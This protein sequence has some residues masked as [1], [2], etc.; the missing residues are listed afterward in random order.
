[1]ALVSLGLGWVA[2]ILTGPAL[3]WL[4]FLVPGFLSLPLL[5][6][7]R[8]LFLLGLALLAFSLGGGRIKL[9][10]PPQETLPQYLGQGVVLEGV[11]SGAPE[12][13]DSLMAVPFRVK[14]VNGEE[15]GG[16]ARLWVS[17]REVPGYGDR[18]RVEGRL[19]PKY[20]ALFRPRLEVLERGRGFYPWLHRLRLDLAGT[21]TRVLPEPPAALAQ[22]MVLGLRGNIPQDL[23]Q[24]F[25][26][27]GT[28][29]ILSISG[30]HVG[31]LA[32]VL[33]SFFAWALG[34]ERPTY[35]ILA[36]LGVWFYVFLA[37]MPSPA[38]RSGVMGS[39]FL[40]GEG[41]GRQR[42]GMV[43][44]VFAAAAMVG[45][46][47]PLL[48]EVSFQLSFLAMAGLVF[49]APFFQDLGRRARLPG[50]LV[51][52]LAYSLGAILATWPLIAY[53]FRIVSLVGL[54]A[55]LLALPALPGLIVFSGLAAG[56]ALLW[57]LLGQG[58]AWL[59]WPFLS[60]LIGLVELF[61]RWPLAYFPLALSPLWVWAYY[62]G[63]VVL[64]GL[65]RI[66]VPL[67]SVGRFLQGQTSL[68]W[69]HLPR[70][71]LALA[72]LLLA[73]L[74]WAAA[75]S[76]PDGRLR[77]SFL[78]VGNG[79]AI[80]IQQGSTQVLVD[81]GPS[82]QAMSRALGQAMPFWD[83]RVE[84]VVLSHPHADHLAGLLEVL[85]RYDVG[86][87]VESG[88]EHPSALYREWEQKVAEK[89]VPRLLARAGQELRLDGAGLTVLHPHQDPR[90]N[91]DPNE[92]SVVLR[93]ELGRV[94]FLLTGDIGEET[95][96]ELLAERAPM[97]ASVLKV[98]HQGSRTSNSEPFL[99]QVR[100]SAAVILASKDNPY[101]HPSPQV[102]TRLEGVVGKN[103]YLTSQVG[104]ITFTTHGGRLWVKTE[105]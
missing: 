100:P 33:L 16:K 17:P 51:D 26:R 56:L 85:R 75:L 31:V 9:L 82:P 38:I 71:G 90:A 50:F 5:L 12:P 76:V 65:F 2:G 81:G 30:L 87:V 28:A 66:K 3:P 79:D 58:V 25:S 102:V 96:G 8:P 91:A 6:R 77:V 84:A 10:P 54:P 63:L 74:A 4:L 68:W 1:M 48:Q 15:A 69:Q 14:R 99:A 53:Y 86:L 32:G 7:R 20:P 83:R 94:S 35:L 23:N 55:T 49:L 97:E 72:L 64:F 52:S 11:V 73:V 43:A 46:S 13:G 44:L 93:L 22:G 42:S 95:E 45:L 67:F 80:L 59:A 104:T 21:L 103:L 24:A 19:E 61:A 18:L 29:H 70:R 37:G 34:R 92:S 88:L 39:L 36:F 98:A 101:G 78:E 62:G 40:A 47:P 57:A 41:L 105:R 89:G 27:T 60:Y